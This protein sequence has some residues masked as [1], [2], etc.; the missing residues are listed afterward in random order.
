M[1]GAPLVFGDHGG[2]SRLRVGN[3]LDH[4]R[5]ERREVD[6]PTAH[7][8]VPRHDDVESAGLADPHAPD[9]MGLGSSLGDISPETVALRVGAPEGR[10]VCHAMG[11]GAC[12]TADHVVVVM[13]RAALDQRHHH[14]D[15]QDERT[16]CQL[17]F[18]RQFFLQGVAKPTAYFYPH[19]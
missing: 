8:V 12:R 2:P 17:H 11:D 13:A 10:D 9:G 14:R 18:R 4:L 5:L 15:R 19:T 1:R 16:N 6:A 7:P 3:D